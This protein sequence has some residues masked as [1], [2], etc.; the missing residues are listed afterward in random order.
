MR[1]AEISK[2]ATYKVLAGR[3]ALALG[4]PDLGVR[5]GRQSY[6]AGTQLTAL[7]YPIIDMP[8]GKPERALLLS[9]AR[10]ESNFAPG[11]KSSAGARGLMQLM[12]ATA[13]AV[14]RSI[15]TRFSRSRLTSDPDYNIHLGRAY[16]AGLIDQ[17]G[18]SYVLAIAG[19]NA[20]PGSVQR[21]IRTLGDPRFDDV[22]VVD[23][24]E[25][26]PFSETR[27][28]VQRVLENLQVYRRRINS[29]KIAWSLEHDLRR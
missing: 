11:A 18:G 14:S 6:R 22:D 10:Q 23:W 3:L 2:D 16:L 13:R 24:I 15:K 25:Q 5:I 12:P 27:N 17:Y 20:G 8:D 26:I 1:L 19:Y 29:S 28:Y 4:R 21:W 9:V 7:A